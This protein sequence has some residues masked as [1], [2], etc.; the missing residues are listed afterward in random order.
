MRSTGQ[1]FMPIIGAND[2]L[3]RLFAGTKPPISVDLRKLEET[4]PAKARIVEMLR[5][6][7]P[8]LGS[9]SRVCRMPTC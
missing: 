7:S 1:V 4:P 8:T 6:S 3:P 9:P 2:R 5:A